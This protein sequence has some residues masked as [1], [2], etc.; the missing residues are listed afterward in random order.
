[1]LDEKISLA[2]RT[3]FYSQTL[4]A[5]SVASRSE[6]SSRSPDALERDAAEVD[7]SLN[8]AYHIYG[9]A[10]GRNRDQAATNSVK[11][12]GLPQRLADLDQRL[13]TLDTNLDLFLA[14]TAT[15]MRH[16]RA[17]EERSYSRCRRKPNI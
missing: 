15:R 11:L 17:W 7:R 12:A 9:R 6:A 10:F 5:S 16:L 3:E 2:K 4:A 13:A 8:D 14:D 1:L